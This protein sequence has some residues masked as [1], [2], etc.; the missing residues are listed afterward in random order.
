MLHKT[1]D[2]LKIYKLLH[3]IHECEDELMQVWIDEGCNVE[4]HKPVYSESAIKL[5]LAED[6]YGIKRRR[7]SL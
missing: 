5:L 6:P 2:W 4:N 1:S 7:L 3:Y